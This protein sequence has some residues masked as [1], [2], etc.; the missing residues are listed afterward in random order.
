MSKLITKRALAESIKAL[1]R[2]RPFSKISVEDIC[3][4]ADVS[5]RNF[6]RYF[7]DKYELLN[8]VY[9]EDYFSRLTIREDWT[10]W[11]YFPLICHHCYEDRTFFKNALSIDGQNSLRSYVQDL[12]RPLIVHD[13]EDTFLSDGS[14]DFY[15]TRTTDALFDYMQQW[16]RSDPC[17]PPDAFSA[18][19][20][21]SVAAHAK[22]AWEIASASPDESKQ[23]QND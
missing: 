6:Y 3:A 16:L 21:A 20:K 1:M 4:R 8:W 11:D 23:S 5:R 19:V 10:I 9:Y 7:P 17:M 2:E 22:R 18:Y 14:E 15:V 13:F 12:L